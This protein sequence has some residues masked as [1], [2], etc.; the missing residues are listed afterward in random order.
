ILVVDD[1]MTTLMMLLALLSTQGYQVSS[2]QSG[3]EALDLALKQPPDLILLDFSL[4][5]MDGL[6]VCR[7][8]KLNPRTRDIPILFL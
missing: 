1:T 2:A 3:A 7:E 4:P 5:G 6:A 8:L